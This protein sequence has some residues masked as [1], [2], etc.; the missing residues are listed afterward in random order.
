VSLP[1]LSVLSVRRDRKDRKGQV[2]YPF[3]PVG[4]DN[5]FR[6]SKGFTEVMIKTF[7]IL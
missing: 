6:Y 5:R 2:R 3:L 1:V 7:G 4:P